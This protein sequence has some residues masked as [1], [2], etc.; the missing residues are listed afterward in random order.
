[1]ILETA[2]GMNRE[3]RGPRENKGGQ[4]CL[5]PEKLLSFGVFRVFR[6]FNSGVSV[7]SLSICR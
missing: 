3:P 6:G 7:F 5:P 2:V 1:M 4:R